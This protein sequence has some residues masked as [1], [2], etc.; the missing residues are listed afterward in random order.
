M[1]TLHAAGTPKGVRTMPTTRKVQAGVSFSPAIMDYIDR[2]RNSDEPLFRRRNRSDV[3]N[4]IIEEHAKRA[5]Q[6]LPEM[7]SAAGNM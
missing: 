6:R 3:I 2:L 4:L 5:G 1:H 7:E